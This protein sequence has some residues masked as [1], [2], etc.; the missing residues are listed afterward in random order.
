MQAVIESGQIQ[1]ARG[2]AAGANSAQVVP[3]IGHPLSA[4]PV[5][6]T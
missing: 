5:R 4:S 1:F 3:A 2:P 6:G